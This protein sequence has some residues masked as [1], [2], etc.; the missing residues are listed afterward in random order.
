MSSLAIESSESPMMKCAGVIA[1][2]S[3]GSSD[4]GKSGLEFKIA[5]IC[6]KIVRSSSYFKV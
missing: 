4:I 2:Q 3:L 1:R 6:W 5:S